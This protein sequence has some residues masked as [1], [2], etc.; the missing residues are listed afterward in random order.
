VRGA[1]WLRGAACGVIDGDAASGDHRL[2]QLT[3]VGSGVLSPGR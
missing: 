2:V 3:D 1:V